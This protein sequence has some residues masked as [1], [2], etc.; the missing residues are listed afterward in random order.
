M[1]T[2]DYK[3]HAWARWLY[4]LCLIIV[5][6]AVPRTAR[7][8][9]IETFD[10]M[11]YIK[12]ISVN[13]VSVGLG[14][15]AY[16]VTVPMTSSDNKHTW[17]EFEIQINDKTAATMADLGYG[18]ATAPNNP[19]MVQLSSFVNNGYATHPSSWDSARPTSIQG[20]EAGVGTS[21]Y[22]RLQFYACGSAVKDNK[23]TITIVPE[24]IYTDQYGKEAVTVRAIGK[25]KYSYD[26]YSCLMG[27]TSTM[28]YTDE[29]HEVTV[30]V[31]IDDSKLGF[32]RTNKSVAYCGSFERNEKYQYAIDLYEAK[33]QL[34]SSE[35]TADDLAAPIYTSNVTD[36]G[37]TSLNLTFDGLT[38]DNRKSVTLYPVIRYIYDG[39]PTTNGIDIEPYYYDFQQMIMRYVG[40]L[41]LPGYA[42]A[43]NVNVEYN[44]V[45][46]KWTKVTWEATGEGDNYDKDG[47]WYIYRQE[48][49]V[50][51]ADIECLG[52]TAYDKLEFRDEDKEGHLEYGGKYTYTVCFIPNGW[53]SD[54]YKNAEGLYSQK[55]FTLYRTFE[56]GSTT[57]EEPGLYTTSEKN[58]NE[59]VFHWTHTAIADAASKSYKMY[60]DRTL[61]PESSGSWEELTSMDIKSASLTSGSYTDKNGLELY[62]TYYYRLRINV[63]DYDYVST[64]VAG[65]LDGG[66][67]ITNITASRGTYTS[68]VKLQ[69]NV[70]QV[71]SNKSYFVLSRRPLGSTNDADYT[72][73]YNTSGTD[74]L[75]SYDDATARSGSYYEYRVRI[76]ALHKGEQKGAMSMSTDG[77][78]V[79][80]G[81]L[82]GRVYYGTG[83]AVEGVKVLLK[84]NDGDG[85]IL[86]KFRSIDLT[87]DGA[88]IA[89]EP[90]Y[91]KMS[92]LLSKDFTMQMYVNPAA[93]SA[94]GQEQ[95]LI[96]I[97]GALYVTL[98]ST[99]V[100]G[101]QRFEVCYRTSESGAST[102]LGI[103]VKEDEWSSL[104]LA[105]NK[106]SQELKAYVVSYKDGSAEP[107]FRTSTLTD[108]VT[109]AVTEPDASGE[110]GT[111]AIKIGDAFGSANQY[112]GL[113][114]EFRFWTKTLSQTDVEKN[115]FHTLSGSESKLAIYWPMD[116][117]MQNQVV[118]YDLSQT[119]DAANECHAVVTNASSSENIP[120]EEMLSLCSLTDGEGNYVLRGV[121]FSGTGT[122]YVVTPIFGI[123]E[124]SPSSASCYLS[125]QSTVH[126][127]IDFTDAS[128]FPVSGLVLYEGTT[129]P[130]EG[131]QL[132]V[133]GVL[134]AKDGKSIA[135]DANGEFTVDVPIGDH[136]ISLSLNGHTF[137]SEG[138]YPEDPDGVGARHTFES[139][140]SGLKFYDNTKVVVAGRVAGGDIEN[141]KPLGVGAGKANLG[142]A[143]INLTFNGSDRYYINSKEVQNGLSISYDIN[144]Q[145]RDFATGAD[146]ISSK[147]YV[148]GNKNV[149]TI[150]TDPKTGEW[151]A[152]LP[153]LKYSAQSIV[154][155]TQPELDFTNKLGDINASNASMIMTDSIESDQP[156]LDGYARFKYCAA[157]K[158][159]YRSES[160]FDVIQNEDG[161][162]GEKEYEVATLSG[163]IDT[164]QLYNVDEDGKVSYK[165]GH[166]VFVQMHNY[167]FNIKA[168]EQYMNN[169]GEK[170]VADDVP[171]G[172]LKVTAKNQ[173]ATSTAVVLATGEVA[174][175]EGDEFELDSLGCATYQFTA[176]LPNLQSPY[177]R[178]MA[179]SYNIDD[180]ELAWDGND[181][182]QSI[183]VGMLP[184]GNDF[185]T[186][187]PDK[188]L[189]IL[190]DPPGSSSSA[191]YSKGS[192]HTK[193]SKYTNSVNTGAGLKTTTKF[194]VKLATFVGLGV[195]VINEAENKLELEVGLD[196][197]YTYNH[198]NETTVTTTSKTDIST[199]DS[200]D[201]VGSKGDVYIGVSTNIVLGECQDL[202]IVKNE[203]SGEYEFK[204]ADILQSSEEFTTSF[205]YTQDYIETKLIPNL[206]SQRDNLLQCV[207]DVNSVARPKKGSDP[208][209]VTT[210]SPEDSKFGTS[211][212]DKDVW[213]SAAVSFGGSNLFEAGRWD[214]PSYSVILPE[215]CEDFNDRVQYYNSQV[216]GWQNIIAQNEKAKV[217]AINGGELIKNFSFDGGASITYEEGKETGSS[218]SDTHGFELNLASSQKF[219]VDICGTGVDFEVSEHVNEAANW[220]D[221]TEDSDQTA[222]SF[223]L[224]DDSNND[225][226]S[227]DVY[228]DKTY[229]F[230]PIFYTRAGATSGPYEDEVVTKYYKPGTVIQQKTLQ[231]EKPELEILDPIVT[232]VPA[233]KD[234]TFRIVMHNN[235]ETKANIYYGIR[236]V[237]SSNPDG[238]QIF[239]DGKNITEGAQILVMGGESVTKTLMLRQTN[240]DI[241]D[242]KDIVLH[243]YAITQPDD[244]FSDQTVSVSFQPTCTDI[245]LAATTSVVN[246]DSDVPVTFSMSG[247]DY[248][249]SS[250]S[251][252]R[253][254]YK[255]ENDA[256]F[257]NLQVFVKDADKAASDPT[258]K[259]FKALT[260]TEKL[261]HMVDLRASD[262]TDQ[263]YIFRAQTVGY[264]GGSEVTNE[265]KEIRI[266]RD[267]SRPQLITNPTPANGVLTA[268]GNITLT[269]NEDISQNILTKTGNFVVTG[270]M[271]ETEVAH[272]VAMDL[273]GTGAAK[274]TATIDLSDRPFSANLWINYTADG[275]ILQ[276]GTTG[277]NFTASIREGKLVIAVGD[278]EVVS[279]NT[280]PIG[281]WLFLAFNY[282]NSGEKPVVSASYAQDADVVSL[283]ESREIAQ[284]EGNGP[285]AVGGN[286]MKAHMQELTLWNSAR[287]ISEALADRNTTKDPYT[288]GL[289]G[290]WQLSEGHGTVASDRARSRDLTLPAENAWFINGGENYAVK[291][292]GATVVE[293][294]VSTTAGEDDSY[295]VE[296]WFN[297]PEKG[298]SNQTIVS[299]GKFMD[300]NVN[301]AGQVVTTVGGTSATAY[302]TNVCDG[303][304]H[305]LA[306]NVLKGSNGSASLFIDGL[307]RKQFAAST[308]PGLGAAAHIV[309]G[310][311]QKMNGE[312]AVYDQ[313]MTGS[314]DELRVWNG[315]RTADVVK[316]TMYQRVTDDTEG[317][318]AYYP[319]EVRTLDSYGQIVTTSTAKEMKAGNKSG[320]SMTANSTLKFDKDA[321]A[322]ASAPAL[323]NVQ[324]DYVTNE[325]QITIILRDEPYK[326]ENCNVTI[327]VK[328]VKDLNG[329]TSQP[330]TWTIFVQQNQMKWVE[331]EINIETTNGQSETFTAEIENAGATSD[332]W[333]L[334]GIPSW[335]TVNAES[336]NLA[337]QGSQKLRFTVD[338]STS[339]GTYESTIYLTG[340]QNIDAPLNITLKVKGD[341]PDW[342]PMPDE[343]TMNIVAQINVDGIVCSDPD[344]ML[345]AFRGQECVGVAKPTYSSRYDAYFLMLN[346][347]GNSETEDAA[348]TYKFYDASTGI[349]YPSVTSSN[350][351]V[352]TY[353][354]NVLI[355]SFQDWVVFNPENKIEQDLSLDRTG[356]KWFSMYVTPTDQTIESIFTDATGKIEVVKSSSETTMYKDDKWA[357]SLSELGLTTM[358]KLRASEAY[359][360]TSIGVPAD[361]SKVD[362]TI[363]PETW[364]WI[365]YPVSATNSV[366][367][368]FA[369]ADP[370]DGDIVKSQNAFATYDGGDWA[371]S[372]TSMTPGEGYKYYSA[373]SSQKT[374]NFQA[375]ADNGRKRFAARP[376][377]NILW[378]TSEDNM[379]VI[380]DVMLNGEPIEGSTISVY[381]GDELCGYS[382]PDSETGLHFITVGSTDNG[383][384]K[385][386]F[387]VET[388]DDTYVFDALF[389][390]RADAVIG[391]VKNPFMLNLDMATGIG[392]QYAGKAIDRIEYYDLTGRLISAEE[393]SVSVKN[394]KEVSG[395]QVALKRVVYADGTSRVFKTI[396]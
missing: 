250:F 294:P 379:S 55:D 339:V 333:T 286:G 243:M 90:G 145:Q 166:P 266:V 222:F 100:D 4:S 343:E 378:L 296:L 16:E 237:A 374:F 372:L 151:S 226:L 42:Y 136:F 54:S 376:Q 170:P 91:E 154:I 130:V 13:P 314:I 380:A 284:Y 275:T 182:F 92:G 36:F 315:R 187:G 322:L 128:S 28:T 106:A 113:V 279:T 24:R 341:E 390:F 2:K 181:S 388:E 20:K 269:F 175:V 111:Q 86:N 387:V 129:I 198:E 139:A 264:R 327:T 37:A 177:T 176:G 309:L 138:R 261:T 127:G 342:N 272:E 304:W 331:D 30:S 336:G 38:L 208:I 245:D 135:T 367:A 140:V 369:D 169:D 101:K 1:K 230:S 394:V 93:A 360:E 280:L 8:E 371:G 118:T 277:N 337:P 132:L 137:V 189:M 205:N 165:F 40:P 259:V 244:V 295:M 302:A 292:D 81:V 121:P 125:A 174:E 117:G 103:Y 58:K 373:A 23:V 51:N 340:S 288:S 6:T 298:S 396:E 256:N 213:G 148:A 66:S 76:Y 122:N 180:T 33:P 352:F 99:T 146:S 368:A 112:N 45:Y 9:V 87:E 236:V 283:F 287:S 312:D 172:N 262:Y 119:N 293:A 285:L 362:I 190:R 10:G 257:K 238:A 186:E 214:G 97:P 370:Q 393:T 107:E 365:G 268:G 17:T 123:H 392:S 253:L 305:H 185:V 242:Y 348:L 124:F 156:E 267:M 320:L 347:Y 153:P 301:T 70:N 299:L 349:I 171:L 39:V 46:K 53:N 71:G 206:L 52:S 227:V 191:T 385:L 47:K 19:T 158:V 157:Y 192:T 5:L 231:V 357:G 200:P 57:G 220:G 303:Q 359:E 282:D 59:I 155:P 247:Y 308:M 313:H 232:G 204:V 56:F 321:P 163:A 228:R 219:G 168:Y 61:T 74:D 110:N 355:G 134:A 11:G 60:V 291:L 273:T 196:A 281:K 344:D 195:G 246:T 7:S 184:K 167:V 233:G 14:T 217:N 63:Q 159:E 149:I 311:R 329:N 207:S 72:D 211:N 104:S 102:G 80:T 160:H 209:Y 41:T 73:I 31:D 147:T 229:G 26:E 364:T 325:R 289:I 143:K 270:S 234:A 203:V 356:W 255:G 366:T 326:I 22:G 307:A 68:V 306:L 323:E 78:C 164:L 274:T 248:N 382:A 377:A 49:G 96:T 361:P 350:D 363:E 65:Q 105:Y 297:I 319:M 324:F 50:E 77:Y 225:Y 216:R 193:K 188:P 240:Q 25:S 239:M 224:A 79:Q 358:Y 150:E 386:R 67:E 161:S 310:A 346:I 21:T 64:P 179:F 35:I 29:M 328:N 116:E 258:L 88:S 141:E 44:D 94:T 178:T 316:S 114:D 391:S 271:N 115:Y 300:V 18:V 69:W 353:K 84:P 317:L 335:L 98:K 82:S 223:T 241:L 131:A 235:S 3:Q 201:F 318:E 194:G 43:T 215:E 381:A 197:N 32:A 383:S 109:I 221:T 15:T 218:I 133:D 34:E 62:E 75:Y 85:E 108:N 334:K 278:D 126:S 48:A 389:D 142:Q 332:S 173:M 263:A 152:L 83:T 351:K 254:Q 144:D 290:Y 12:G 395:K 202:S 210:L 345:A 265:S 276:H 384:R 252:I 338:P 89:Y 183:V 330:I 260:G 354:S 162:F 120:D 212:N 249:Q 251:E 95:S 27:I 375:P 199:S